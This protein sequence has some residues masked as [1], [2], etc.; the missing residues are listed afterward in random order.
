MNRDNTSQ[1]KLACVGYGAMGS[2]IVDMLLSSKFIAPDYLYVA[3]PHT[4][5]LSK[6][7]EQGVHTASS[8]S[9][10]ALD[11]IDALLL[12]IKPQGFESFFKDFAKAIQ[13]KLIISIAAG[14]SIAGIQG[15]LKQDAK[16]ARVMPNLLASIAEAAS[17]IAY[18]TSV[19]DEE[20]SFI[21]G[22]FSAT[23]SATVIDESK[24]DAASVLNGCSP[25]FFASI[26]DGFTVKAVQLGIPAKTARLLLLQTM[27]GTAELLLS[28]GVHPKEFCEKVCSPA[29]TTI[30]G[31]EV[32]N[33]NVAVIEEI[34][35]ASY[36][37][38]KE[39]AQT[40]E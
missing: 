12:A 29:G 14:K 37:R 21:E 28:S 31:V 1:Y 13:D 24:M 7:A 15:A 26:I 23:G 30:E 40:G 6:L 35:A 39:L 4:E 11:E 32:I 17:V 38:S 9:E 8:L 36:R 22:I 34:V 16:V 20:K 27:Q 5:R 25:A 18:A 3:D 10:F 33:H 19:S 2:A